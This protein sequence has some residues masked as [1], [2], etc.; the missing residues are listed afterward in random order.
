MA[1]PPPLNIYSLV[2]IL[3]LSVSTILLLKVMPESSESI[4]ENSLGSVLLQEES[5]IKTSN[6]SDKIFFMLIG[7]S[8]S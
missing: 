8:G 4:L 2:R 7:K 3:K 5:V 6:E 1:T